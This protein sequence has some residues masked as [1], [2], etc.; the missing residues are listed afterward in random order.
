MPQVMQP[1]DP[2]Q[3]R[4]QPRSQAFPGMGPEAEVRHFSERGVKLH[5]ELLSL[6]LLGSGDSGTLV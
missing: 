3:E 4:V 1:K 5:T 2:G 6:Q